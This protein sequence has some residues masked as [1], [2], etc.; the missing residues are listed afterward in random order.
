[1]AIKQLVIV[2]RL[3]D[4]LRACLLYS[5]KLSGKDSELC[6]KHKHNYRD[7]LLKTRHSMLLYPNDPFILQVSKLQINILSPPKKGRWQRTITNSKCKSV[8]TVTLQL[9]LLGMGGNHPS[10][11]Q[12]VSFP[13]VSYH[14]NIVL[15]DL[16]NLKWE[17]TQTSYSHYSTT[18]RA[19]C[20][21]RE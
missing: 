20:G 5:P 1:M 15:S 7:F 14:L 11:N 19:C 13:T 16:L 18:P 3:T 6:L 9:Y 21:S 10:V 2:Q 12:P 4:T 17:N 8:T